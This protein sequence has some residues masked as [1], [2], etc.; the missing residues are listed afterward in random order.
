MGVGVSHVANDSWKEEGERVDGREDTESTQTVC[1][2]LPV[3]QRIP[4]VLHGKIIG[5]FVRV[6]CNPST[7]L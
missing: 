6:V 2:D 7:N 5:E 3:F 4:D 1:P